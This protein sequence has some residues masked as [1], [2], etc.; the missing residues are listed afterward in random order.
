MLSLGFLHD[1]AGP[2]KM[3]SSV[4]KERKTSPMVKL[5][6]FKVR[7][8]SHGHGKVLECEN[9]PKSWKSHGIA[10][11]HGH[12]SFL[13]CDCCACCETQSQPISETMWQWESWK[14]ANQSWNS[15]F[16]FLWEPCQSPGRPVVGWVTTYHALAAKLS[17]QHFGPSGKE[18]RL[19]WHQIIM[20]PIKVVEQNLLLTSS[21]LLL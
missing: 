15:V 19:V 11:F 1:T 7:Q 6:Q 4:K 10:C 18:Q 3:P 8:G 21:C 17:P 2:V 13:V 5:I 9:F 16:R 12:S 14:Q 20:M